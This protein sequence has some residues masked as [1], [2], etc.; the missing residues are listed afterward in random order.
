MDGGVAELLL[1][2]NTTRAHS[3]DPQPRHDVESAAGS[4]RQ[5]KRSGAIDCEKVSSETL[6][7]PFTDLCCLEPLLTGGLQS[8]L[9]VALRTVRTARGEGVG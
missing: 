2:F 5:S 6:D 8:P 9:S 3:P 1:L 4:N 7:S